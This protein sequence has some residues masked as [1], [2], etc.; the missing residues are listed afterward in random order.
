VA[1]HDRSLLAAAAGKGC[2]IMSVLDDAGRSSSPNPAEL[3][4]NQLD[5]QR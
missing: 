4:E 1:G 5:H 2:A 3:I